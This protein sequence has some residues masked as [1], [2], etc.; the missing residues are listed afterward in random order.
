LRAGLD[1]YEKRINDT[2]GFFVI[3]FDEDEFMPVIPKINIPEVLG[4]EVDGAIDILFERV[5]V[6]FIQ[7]CGNKKGKRRREARVGKTIY[8]NPCCHLDLFVFSFGMND[9]KF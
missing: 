5:L 6:G 2:G 7:T 1:P 4:E 8:L 3:E 9:V